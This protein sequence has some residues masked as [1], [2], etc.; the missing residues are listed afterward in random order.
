MHNLKPYIY[1]KSF[2]VWL[3]RLMVYRYPNINNLKNYYRF[4]YGAARERFFG[5]TA[6]ESVHRAKT[7]SCI[8]QLPAGLGLEI[9]IIIAAIIMKMIIARRGRGKKSS[10]KTDG[11]V[12]CGDGSC[13]I[14]TATSTYVIDALQLLSLFLNILLRNDIIIVIVYYNNES[15]SAAAAVFCSR[16]ISRAA[17]RIN[18]LGTRFTAGG[19]GGHVLF[20]RIK[21]AKNIRTTWRK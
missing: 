4:M 6:D 18:N 9:I 13:G 21:L 3:L 2:L 14:D 12:S 5:R 16:K 10:N 20:C 19:G 8:N 7:K 1:L 17:I 15:G 11:V